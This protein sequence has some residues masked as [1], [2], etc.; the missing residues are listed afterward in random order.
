MRFLLFIA[1]IFLAVTAF[2]QNVREGT[3]LHGR[4]RRTGESQAEKL[5]FSAWP[6][7]NDKE[8]GTQVHVTFDYHNADIIILAYPAPGRNAMQRVGRR[9]T[10]RLGM[11][12]ADYIFVE[13]HTYGSI[14][15]E[16]NKYLEKQERTHSIQ[17]DLQTLR[18]ALENSP[19]LPKPISLRIDGSDAD[20]TTVRLA[21]ENENAV[22]KAAFYRLVDLPAGA[23]VTFR[24]SITWVAYLSAALFVG[25]V[26]LAVAMVATRP[27]AME[28]AKLKRL[29]QAEEAEVVLP[30]EEVQKRYDRAMPIY[31]LTL[32]TVLP[33]ALFSLGTG[34]MNQGLKQAARLVGN[35]SPD[36]KWML[37]SPFLFFGAVFGGSR[38]IY[39]L[40]LRRRSRLRPEIREAVKRKT[41]QEE[42]G[43]RTAR[44]VPLMFIPV[45]LMMTVTFIPGVKSFDPTVRRVLILGSMFGGWGL[46]GAIAWRLNRKLRPARLPGDPV[47][48]AA[49]HFARIAGVKVRRVETALSQKA[50]AYVTLFG[51]VG[52]TRG[53]VEKC[54]P[55]EVNAVIAHEIGHMKARHLSKLFPLTL[56]FSILSIAL[57]QFGVSR[58]KDHVSEG[59][60]FVL[61]S[62]FMFI[63]VLPLISSFVF[64]RWRRKN[65]READRFA[66]EATGDPE[67]VIR[68]LS[69]IHT[70][71][72][73]PYRLKPIDEA[74]SSHPSLQNRID[75]IR[76]EVSAR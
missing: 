66:V 62:P 48:E 44:L 56:L 36:P 26:L 49:R 4:L 31:L 59:L 14:D 8:T 57:Y 33:F 18:Q 3:H 6:H 70:L 53:L 11:P 69:K 73:T 60:F 61:D 51:T 47:Y 27:W 55:D 12:K 42:E 13:E 68:A 24:A 17:I 54:D 22:Q 28:K 38:L 72:E 67:L 74:L 58:I 64:G 40:D 76:E 39:A 2:G 30:P 34:F 16:L 25:I 41:P 65:E 29:A 10:E 52:V 63:F 45:L 19:E 15:I 37:L 21:S 5:G 23:T 43:V 46:A 9:V 20:R 50:N 32:L 35:V 71:N 7:V 75:A 1:G